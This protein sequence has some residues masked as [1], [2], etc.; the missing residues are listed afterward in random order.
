[1][2]DNGMMVTELGKLCRLYP[3]LFESY[4]RMDDDSPR[5]FL[6]DKEITPMPFYLGDCS[7]GWIFINTELHDNLLSFYI[8]TETQ[9]GNFMM[10]IDL[11]L[12][13]EKCMQFY[14]CNLEIQRNEHFSNDNKVKIT[15]Y[16]RVMITRRHTIG[17]IIEDGK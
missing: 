12:S 1:M 4:V 3:D 17:N 7:R 8:N 9:E 6:R 13:D 10:M 11:N 5:I 14:N 15:H 2:M 16:D